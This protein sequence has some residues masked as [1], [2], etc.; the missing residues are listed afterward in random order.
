[1]KKR[2]LL[3]SVVCL[4]AA[5]STNSPQQMSGRQLAKCAYKG[6]AACQTELQKRIQARNHQV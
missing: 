2:I 3:I 6:D 1:M 4:L 5:C